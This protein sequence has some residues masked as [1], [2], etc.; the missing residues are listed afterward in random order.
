MDIFNIATSI[1]N[2]SNV[3]SWRWNKICGK[4]IHMN[5]ANNVYSNNMFS[6]LCLMYLLNISTWNK[7]WVMTSFTFI[8]IHKLKRLTSFN[9]GT[10]DN[11]I[12]IAWF[13]LYILM[14]TENMQFFNRI[15]LH[16]GH[17]CKTCN[18]IKSNVSLIF[19]FWGEEDGERY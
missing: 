9:T 12:Y 14:M 1:P 18:F 5:K 16:R 10:H 15:P 19:I 4:K 11:T 8:F 17:F 7:Y 3:T 2:G 13:H 6:E